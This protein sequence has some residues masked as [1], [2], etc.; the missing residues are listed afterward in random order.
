MSGYL[1]EA[2]PDVRQMAL[3]LIANHLPHLAA[4][5]SEIAI[6]FKEKASKKGGQAV[7]G[8]TSK[9]PKILDVLGKQ[10]YKFILEL[11]NDEWLGL[12][13]DQKKALLFHLLCMCGVEED[14]ETHELKF[15]IKAPQ[16]SYFYDEIKLFGDWR[17]R[18]QE[19]ESGDVT[20]ALED[21]NT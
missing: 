1:V 19:D 2:G 7:L 5:D 21:A 6:I 8:K 4:C 17:P 14:P 3:E 15:T 11:G 18:A 13:P 20:F 9:A 12:S 10:E 16:L